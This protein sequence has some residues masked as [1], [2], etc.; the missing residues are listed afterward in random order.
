MDTPRD[1]HHRLHSGANFLVDIGA[2]DPRSPAGGFAEVIFPS[3]PAEPPVGRDAARPDAPAPP[4]ASASAQ[5][6]VLR[7]G[8]TGNLDL[9]RWWDE[10]RRTTAPLTR[11]VTVQLLAGDHRTVVMT[12]RFLGAYPVQLSYSPCAR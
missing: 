7:R 4:A 9:Y 5:R 12:W 2:A 3:L 10:T 6:L 11:T 1:Q 8:V